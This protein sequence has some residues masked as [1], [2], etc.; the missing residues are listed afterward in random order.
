MK[1]SDLDLVVAGTGD[2]VLMVESEARELSEEIM[3]GAVMF[4]HQSFQPVLDAI[5]RLAE[6]A[7]RPPRELA[8]DEGSDLFA[9]IRRQ[10]R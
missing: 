8:H 4:G 1:K 2:A 9:N 3:L 7:A 5:I 10:R 6:R